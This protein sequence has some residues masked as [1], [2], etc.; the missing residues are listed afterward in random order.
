MFHLLTLTG[1]KVYGL[2]GPYVTGH[3]RCADTE[4]SHE[5]SLH[6]RSPG[7]AIKLHD[8][9]SSATSDAGAGSYRQCYVSSVCKAAVVLRPQVQLACHALLDLVGVH[10]V[11]SPHS[12]S[13]ATAL[14]TGP[15]TC[16][17]S[18]CHQ[19]AVL[20]VGL[21]PSTPRRRGRQGT[22]LTGWSPSD[23]SDSLS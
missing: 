9:R 5:T 14:E 17:H 2:H 21:P 1:S 12:A 11:G 10:W 20:P 15:C 19:T 8:T 3:G 23:V 22:I 16:L 6:Q 4:S 13:V 7:L 18:T